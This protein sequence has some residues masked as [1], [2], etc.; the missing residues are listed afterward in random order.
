[1]RIFVGRHYGDM[2]K[3]RPITAWL[4]TWDAAGPSAEFADEVAAILSS[5]KSERTV[6]ELVEFLYAQVTSTA[7]ELAEYA[8][9]PK[10]NPYRANIGLMI[11]EV[12]HGDRITCGAHPW[13]YARKVTDLTITRD[14]TTGLETVAWK[15]PRTFRWN[16]ARTG[17]E[18]A[19]AGREARVTRRVTG[20]LSV[21]P[22]WDREAGALKPTFAR[23]GV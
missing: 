14:E 3:K 22:I 16:A 4:V 13:L 6:A 5:R 1:M 11:N 8:R 7:S 2:G 17:I 23:G 10:R 21:E 18:E 12:P 19:Q 15:E 20:S 9:N